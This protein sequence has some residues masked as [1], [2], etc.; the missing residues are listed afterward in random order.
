MAL[1]SIGYRPVP[2]FNAASAMSAVVNVQPISIR[3]CRWADDLGGMNIVADAPPAFL[4]DDKRLGDELGIIPGRFDNRSVVFP[5]DFPSAE[6]MLSKGIRAV[7]LLRDERRLIENDLGHVLFRWQE[8]QI[9][10]MLKIAQDSTP[11]EKLVVSK[12]GNF[13][14]LWYRMMVLMGLARN[15]AG[16]FGAIVPEPS[17]GGGFG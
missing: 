1:A 10:I 13:R 3:L 17:S 2:L 5:Q 8:K 14:S 16:G 15:S 7:V 4:I 9:P 11:P 12:P 6:F